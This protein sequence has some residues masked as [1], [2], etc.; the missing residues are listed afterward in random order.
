MSLDRIISE[1]KLKK[2]AAGQTPME[3][4]LSILKDNDA[5]SLAIVDISAL[6]RSYENWKRELPEV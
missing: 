2:L 1:F 6:K 4:L 5:D 3:Y